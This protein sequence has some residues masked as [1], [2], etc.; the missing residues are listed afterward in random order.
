MSS[1]VTQ[2]QT[3]QAAIPLGELITLDGAGQIL[4][5]RTSAN[6]YTII[7]SF[8]VVTAKENLTATPT[9]L[10]PGSFA[11]LQKSPTPT[12]PS[13]LDPAE[14]KLCINAEFVSAN[15]YQLRLSTDFVIPGNKGNHG[16]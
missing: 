15:N 14:A 12:T 1:V 4:I 2:L 5:N 16:S 13:T 11:V 3:N 8:N 10:D 6:H 7:L 9:N